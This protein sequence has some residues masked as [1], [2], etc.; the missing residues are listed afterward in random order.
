MPYFAWSCLINNLIIKNGNGE[1]K[2][3]RGKNSAL[4]FFFHLDGS[5]NVLLKGTYAFE[6]NPT[7]IERVPFGRSRMFAIQKGA[8]IERFPI[9]KG[10]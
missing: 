8:V 1:G 3:E 5:W 7:V 6:R 10:P 4:R 2:G 9:E